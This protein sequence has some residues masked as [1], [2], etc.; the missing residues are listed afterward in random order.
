MA[1]PDVS[2]D[3]LDCYLADSLVPVEDPLEWWKMNCKVYPNLAKLAILVHLAMGMWSQV[4]LASA[5]I[6]SGSIFSFG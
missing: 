1:L 3:K 6:S 2:I 4:F 5:L